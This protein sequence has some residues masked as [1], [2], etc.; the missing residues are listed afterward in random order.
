MAVTASRHC[1]GCLQPD[2]DLI[3]SAGRKHSAHLDAVPADRRPG[4]LVS[5]V[6]PD[7]LVLADQQ[8]LAGPSHAGGAEPTSP[9]LAGS[10]N[11]TCVW[12]TTLAPLAA[13]MTQGHSTFG[14]GGLA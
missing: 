4:R 3:A 14:A 6:L 8:W 11:G 5:D 12:M 2:A 9:V 13:R 7:D 10:L 1:F